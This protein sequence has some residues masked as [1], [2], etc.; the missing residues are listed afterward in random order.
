[1]TVKDRWNAIM[2]APSLKV[3][4]LHRRKA[5]VTLTA[6]QKMEIGR[7][8]KAGAQKVQLAKDFDVDE[9]TIRRVCQAS[10]QKKCAEQV[11]FGRGSALRV[12]S[13]TYDVLESRLMHMISRCRSQGLPISKRTIQVLAKLERGKM[14]KEGDNS[15]DTFNASG[16]WA[17]AFTRRWGLQSKRVHGEA[18]GVK[19][20]SYQT[21]LEENRLLLGKYKLPNIYN[22]DECGLF[23]RLLPN[24]TYVLRSESTGKVRGIKSMKAKERLTLVVCTSAA[25]QRVP[26]V[27]IGKAKRPQCFSVRSPPQDVS[28]FNQARAWS[29]SITTQRWFGE[30]FLPHIRRQTNDKV[31]LI[32][33]NASSHGQ[34]LI[35]PLGQVTIFN[36]PPNT[37]SVL[38]PADAGIIAALKCR[39]KYDL[40]VEVVARLDK[41]GEAREY[42]KECKAGTK[43][44]QEGYEPHALDAMELISKAWACVSE[45]T[46]SRC[47]AHS[48][49]LPKEYTEELRERWPKRVRTVSRPRIEVNVE[50]DENELD[51][52][53]EN[54]PEI[55]LNDLSKRLQGCSLFTSIP[56]EEVPEHLQGTVEL[57]RDGRVKL[58]EWMDIED[59]EDVQKL[60]EQEHI[61]CIEDILEER[62]PDDHD[63]EEDTLPSKSPPT[64]NIAEARELINKLEKLAIHVPN[65]LPAVRQASAAFFEYSRSRQRQLKISEMYLSTS[66]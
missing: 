31:A 29:D 60:F 18:G 9:T 45:R 27:C 64:V 55:L 10:T 38:Q 52:D 56:A 6:A 50:I 36:L 62:V 13:G 3:G 41:C 47:W 51:P 59:S 43:G 42:F 26:I 65:A 46:I 66:S 35:D 22:M 4:G 11:E 14:M 2:K 49:I 17:V 25:G 12:R 23:Y 53:P 28:Y 63:S 1:M 16:G 57:L 5:R 15:V 48:Q 20:D 32:L 21:W 39:Y 44:L 58:Q 24:R 8:A 37:T 33:D 40:S 54:N 30:I 61:D 19:P 34:D 7:M